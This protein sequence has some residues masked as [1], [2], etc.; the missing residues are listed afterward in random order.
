MELTELFCAIDDFCKL[1]LP[2]FQARLLE[3]DIKSRNRE[4]Q[5]CLSEVMTII[6]YF[7]FSGY[8]AFKWYYQKEIEGH[9][10]KEFPKLVSYNRF[11]RLMP[12]ALIPLICFARMCRMGKNTGISFIDST[13]LEVCNNLRIKFHKVFED[14]AKRGK[15]STGWFFGF[16]LHL[17]VNDKGEILS[18]YVTPGN[19]DDRNKDVISSLTKKVF[20]KLYGDRGYIKQ[21]LFEELLKKGLVLVTK[22]KKNMKNKLMDLTDKI[23]LRKRAVIESINDLLK[24][25]CR[26]QHT[27]HRSPTNWLVNLIAGIIAY[28]FMPKKPSIRFTV[29]N[30]IVAIA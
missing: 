14:L 19:V 13:K 24:N 29:G 17:I 27:R 5:L 12:S 30:D 26:I 4:G 23:L 3:Q 11:V 8:H 7:H 16:K 6:V 10:K 9:L 1:F 28:T 25:G 20:G 2:D 21:E 22:I 15:T 18:F